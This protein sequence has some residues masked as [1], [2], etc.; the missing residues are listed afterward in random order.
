M[1][2]R[3]QIWSTQEAV[4]QIGEY[5]EEE[6]ILQYLIDPS[7]D[8]ERGSLAA[9]DGGVM[10]GFMMTRYQPAAEDVHRVVMDGGVAPDYR[11]KG[12][13]SI[14]LKAGVAAAKEL[15]ALHHPTLRL[16]VDVEKPDSIVGPPELLR[17][18]GF[19]PV[20]YYQHMEHP[21][22]DA[23][24]D[25][26]IP[27][28][29]RIE[30]WS[31]H[32]DEEFRLIRNDAFQDDWLYAP[33]S[34]DSWTSKVTNHT[35]RP[36]VSFLLRDAANGAS[37]GMLVTMSWDGDAAATGIRDARFM[38]IATQPGYRNRGVASALSGRALRTAANEGYDRASLQ[39]DSAN[40]FDAFGV[41]EAAGFTTQRRYVRWALEV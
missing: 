40:P 14:L 34:A 10:V 39:V 25:A 5:Y 41:Y 4:D 7:V 33:M 31:E 26:A 35:F 11:R 2:R 18:Q 16:A 28:G 6:D 21:L 13:G 19:A 24:R 3:G 8:L 15:H 37:A 36:T 27:D 38:Y 29:L 1:R 32:N 12:L 9:F 22:G 23:I 30:P 20:R 17:S